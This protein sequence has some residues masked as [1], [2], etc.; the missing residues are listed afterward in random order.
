MYSLVKIHLIVSKLNNVKKL[1]IFGIAFI[2]YFIDTCPIVR[3][4]IE[5]MA[6]KR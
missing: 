2:P 5:N 4:N 6:I 3:S 1:S